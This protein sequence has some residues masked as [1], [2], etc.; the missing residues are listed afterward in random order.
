MGQVIDINTAR[1]K[2][3]KKKKKKRKAIKK[4]MRKITRAVADPSGPS[5]VWLSFSVAQIAT[6]DE[7]A[8]VI[9]RSVYS[10]FRWPRKKTARRSPLRRHCPQRDYRKRQ[11]PVRATI[12]I[13][14]YLTGN[15]PE[16]MRKKT[17]TIRSEGAALVAAAKMYLKIYEM[18]ETLGGDRAVAPDLDKRMRERKKRGVH[19]INRG[20]EP[21]IW[22]HDIE[23]LVFEQIV[24]K[25]LDK[26]KKTAHI[27]FGIGS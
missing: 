12:E 10:H 14:A 23:D 26:E 1:R 4:R 13:D 7:F 15:V 11:L 17:V 16:K 25:W 6:D 18:N 5:P 27:S 9:S 21:Y 20:S 24:I 2:K 22:G 3:P 8:A 19:I